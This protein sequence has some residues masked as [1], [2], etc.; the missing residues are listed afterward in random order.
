MRTRHLWLIL[1]A[2]LTVSYSGCSRGNSVEDPFFRGSDSFLE[3]FYIGNIPVQA[4]ETFN[5]PLATVSRLRFELDRAVSPASLAQIFGFEIWITNVDR[6]WVFQLST[7]NMLENGDLVWL[8]ETGKL[9]EYR[10]LHN[11]DVV[12]VGGQ[13]MEMGDPG[14]LFKVDVRYLFG[15]AQDGTQFAFSDDEFWVVFTESAQTQ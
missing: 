6:G 7:C 1:I 4:G 2:L 11:M 5:I 3:H 10:M 12:V 15:L 9:I 8:D 14:D 13:S